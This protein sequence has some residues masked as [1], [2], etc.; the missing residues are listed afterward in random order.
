MQIKSFL[1]FPNNLIFFLDEENCLLSFCH[2]RNTPAYKMIPQV[3]VQFQEYKCYCFN[4][5]HSSRFSPPFIITYQR[6]LPNILLYTESK[7]HQKVFF[8]LLESLS[9]CLFFLWSGMPECL[10]KS[11]CMWCYWET[12]K[13]V[14]ENE[15]KLVDSPVSWVILLNCRK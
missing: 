10:L 1:S 15:S 5:S 9:I 3:L 11:L 13:T 8:L 4:K 12:W 2:V 14:E 7:K 6:V